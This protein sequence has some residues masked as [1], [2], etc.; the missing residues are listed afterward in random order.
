MIDPGAAGLLQAEAAWTEGIKG[1]RGGLAQHH[2]SHEPTRERAKKNA[3]AEVAGGDI[4]AG[5]VLQETDDGEPIF[6][7]GAKPGPGTRERLLRKAGEK[8]Q[9][10]RTKAVD[11]AEGHGLLEPDVLDIAPHDQAAV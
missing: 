1:K 6:G 7:L 9:H 8:R 5:Q 3:I 10:K 2:L 11:P 4:Q